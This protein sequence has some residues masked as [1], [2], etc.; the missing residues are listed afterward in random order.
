MNQT[1]MLATSPENL[2]ARL[3]IAINYVIEAI[4]EMNDKK[5]FVIGNGSEEQILFCQEL[6]KKIGLN[7]TQLPNL[8]DITEADVIA[9]FYEPGQLISEVDRQKIEELADKKRSDNYS[10]K[11]YSDGKLGLT[12][13]ILTEDTFKK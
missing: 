5:I 4:Q 13:K 3:N 6:E 8:N 1:E 11:D 7:I 12:I 2:K 9:I 10:G